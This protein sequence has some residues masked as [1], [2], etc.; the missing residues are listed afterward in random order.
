MTYQQQ[1]E[2]HSTPPTYFKTNAFTAPFQ[3]IVNTYG[4][5]RY[6]EI[7]P[8]LFAI[9]F[10]PFLFGVMFGD[11]GHGGLLFFFG[12]YLVFKADSIKEDKESS[13]APLVEMRY[14]LAIMGFFAFYGGFIY[15]EFFAITWNLFGSCYEDGEHFRHRISDDCVYP[16]GIDPKWFGTSNELAF[17]NSFKMK[18]AVIIGVAQMSF[19][20]VLKGLNSINFGLPLDFLFEFVPQLTFL[21][22]TFGYMCFCIVYKWLTPWESFDLNTH[23]APG[24][25]NIMI[26][27]P[28]KMGSTEGEPLYDTTFQEKVQFYFFI[29]ALIMV[30][31]MLFVKPLILLCQNSGAPKKNEKEPLLVKD[32]HGHDE[33]DFGEVFVH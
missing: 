14:L 27:M 4:I 18:M 2:Q 32:S 5:P 1:H 8:G 30:P 7:N 26:N 24:I 12:L 19:G 33:F 31:I 6:G 15:N 25:I 17:F 10:F 22:I 29:S 16:F 21:L 23:P 9:A 3:E 28:L 13:L 20:V 11:I